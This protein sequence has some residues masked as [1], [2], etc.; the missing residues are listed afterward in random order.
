MPLPNT[1]SNSMPPCDATVALTP[2]ADV[3]DKAVRFNTPNHGTP[4]GV[5]DATMALANPA[6]ASPAVNVMADSTVAFAQWAMGNHAAP[7]S[8]AARRRQSVRTR[9][10]TPA[11]P[12]ASATP[13]SRSSPRL[14]IAVSSSPKRTPAASTPGVQSPR[15]GTPTTVPLTTMH[16]TAARSTRG[17]SRLANTSVV[18]E[19]AHDMPEEY[20]ATLDVAIEAAARMTSLVV[21]VVGVCLVV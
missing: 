7:N 13:A 4:E 3:V 5:C 16:G 18:G 11:A 9:T 15:A 17:K 10:S 21:R 6:A 8:A 19:E 2:A 12:R 20:Q 1:A 14:V